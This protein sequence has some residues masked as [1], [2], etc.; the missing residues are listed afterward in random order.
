M[1][2]PTNALIEY[3]RKHDFLDGDFLREAVQLLMQQLIELEVSEQVGAGRDERS[4]GR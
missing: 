1:T 2:E 3:L 4:A